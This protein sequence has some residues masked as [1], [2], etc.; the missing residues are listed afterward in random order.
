MKSPSQERAYLLEKAGNMPVGNT[1]RRVKANIGEND[2]VAVPAPLNQSVQPWGDCLVWR[3]KLNA[4]GYGIASF[5]SREQL[6]HRQTFRQSRKQEA[7]QNVLHLCHRTFCIQPS[8]LYEGSNQ[9]N[10][11]DRGLRVSDDMNPGLWHRKNAI[12]EEA[13]RHRWARPVDSQQ[14]LVNPEDCSVEH[15][16]QYIIPAGDR[17]ICHICGNPPDP[18]LAANLELPKFQPPDADRNVHSVVKQKRTFTKLEDGLTLVAN[19][20]VTL[21]VPKNRAERRRRRKAEKKHPPPSEPV[22]LASHRIDPNT[23]QSFELNLSDS[24]PGPGL[25]V[26]TIRRLPNP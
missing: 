15:K 11:D 19:G 5:S 23:Q 2:Y 8:H 24:I 6:A 10:S 20:R 7:G 18:E 1:R 14:P 21:T 12:A 16:C 17:R 9:E 4:D 26:Y 25:I 13:A 22:L 3:W